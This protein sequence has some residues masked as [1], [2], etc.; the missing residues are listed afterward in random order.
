MSA[1]PVLENETEVASVV[2]EARKEALCHKW[3]E[4]QKAGRDLGPEAIRQWYR[5]H[6]WPF[7]RHC[8][9]LHLQ[10]IKFYSEF[11]PEDFGLFHREFSDPRDRELL[12]EIVDRI[13]RHGAENLNIILWAVQTNLEMDRVR[14]ILERLDI[15]ARRLPWDSFLEMVETEPLAVCPS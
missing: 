4:S 10:G 15:N 3:I 14:E 6:F 7:L 1:T 2:E 5:R 13:Y 12:R 11:D 9:F 8:W